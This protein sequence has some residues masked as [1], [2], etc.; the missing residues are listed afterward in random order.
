MAII[1]SKRAML[2]GS[3]QTFFEKCYQ[4]LKWYT[5]RATSCR[6]VRATAERFL[7]WRSGLASAF[8]GSTHGSV[9]INAA[10]YFCQQ[11]QKKSFTKPW[12]CE[13]TVTYDMT[14]LHYK[15]SHSRVSDK[16]CSPF[17]SVLAGFYPTPGSK[18]PPS[19]G[20]GHITRPISPS[21]LQNSWQTRRHNPGDRT[22]HS[23][24]C[25]NQKS[26]VY[27]L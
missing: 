19:S 6:P 1:F 12:S 20:P 9:Q 17:L 26:I 8:H 15:A 4:P 21:T 16:G 2:H 18:Y 14:A 3:R 5:E 27:R 23:H 7:F 25:R 22:L 10:G 24:C 13:R 11:D